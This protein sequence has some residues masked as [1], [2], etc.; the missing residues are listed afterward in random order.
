M[1]RKCDEAASCSELNKQFI[2]QA[3]WTKTTRNQLYREIGLLNVRRVLEVGCGTGAITRE[4]REKTSAQITA[5]D[6]DPIVLAKA[7]EDIPDVQFYKENAEKL[8]MRDETFDVVICHYFFLWNPQ[9]FKLLMELV[10]V[11]KPGGYIVALAEPD[12]GGW[13]EYPELGLGKK[14]SE[15]LELQGADP[16]MGRKLLSFFESAGLKTS[17]T[18]TAQV[19]DQEKLKENIEM[20]WKN[21][22]KAEEITE[23]EFKDIMEKEKDAIDN[24]LRMIF[25]PV[26]SAIGKKV[27]ND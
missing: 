19:W 6:S 4:L 5:I 13:L 1:S 8:S 11:C 2:R 12:Y 16:Y 15:C 10:R 3:S 24:N 27:K 17:L 26:F 18:V 22:L 20:E 9:P 25:L 14:H 23:E 7:M 21:V